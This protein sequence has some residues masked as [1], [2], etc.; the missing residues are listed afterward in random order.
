MATFGF[1]TWLASGEKGFDLTTRITKQIANVVVGENQAGS[2]SI[3]YPSNFSIAV[4]AIML[5]GDGYMRHFGHNV[6]FDASTKTVHYSPSVDPTPFREFEEFAK[7]KR[8]RTAI[9]VFAYI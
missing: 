6:T 3:N 4:N 2:F 9:I 8:S 1:S 7:V 5:D